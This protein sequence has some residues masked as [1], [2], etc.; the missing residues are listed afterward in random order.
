MIGLHKEEIGS[1][2]TIHAR[3][4]FANFHIEVGKY[5][6]KKTLICIRFTYESP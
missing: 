2:D 5:K 3:Q 4:K 1:M 6:S